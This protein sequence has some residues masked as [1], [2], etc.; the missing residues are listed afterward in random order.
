EG[1]LRAHPK[2]S[3]LGSGPRYS[4]LSLAVPRR[5]LYYTSMTISLSGAFFFTRRSRHLCALWGVVRN[6]LAVYSLPSP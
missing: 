6:Y 5:H 4:R 3:R 2:T 1:V